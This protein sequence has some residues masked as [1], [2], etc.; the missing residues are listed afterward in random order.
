LP[1]EATLTRGKGRH[2]KVKREGRKGN[3]M[4]YVPYTK[5]TRVREK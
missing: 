5:L 4:G 2:R 1:S 3:K